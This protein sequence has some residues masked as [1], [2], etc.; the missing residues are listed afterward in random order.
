MN[1]ANE[2]FEGDRVRGG[3]SSSVWCL[4]AAFGTYF[5][6][7]AFR[8]PFTAAGY[9]DLELGGI[10][11]KA[12]LV[13]AQVLGYTVSKFIGIKVVAEIDPRRRAALLLGLIGV[14]EVALVLFGLTPAPYNL[15]WLF[16]NGL[17]LGMVFGLV[18]GFLEGR[19]HTEALAAGLCASFI[20]ADGVTKSAGAALLA[21]GISEYWMPALAGLL[22]V[23]P[24]LMFTWML[25]RIP[26]PTVHD[27]AARSERTPMNGADRWSFF[28]RYAVG[29]VLLVL[30]YLLV[31]VLRSLRADFAP[32]I[33]AGLQANVPAS[34]FAWSE[35]AVAA[36]VLLLTSATVLIRDNRRAFFAGLAT[37][38]AGALL[39]GLALLGHSQGWLSPF[40]FMVTIG[41]GLYLPYIA[42]HVTI[43]ERLIATTRDRGN[44]G[45]LMYVA[46]SFGYLGYV[47]V[48]LARNL[49][50]PAENFLDFFL[51]ASG[52][53]AV[54]CLVLLVPC[55]RFFA[56]HMAAQHSVEFVAEKRELE[57]TA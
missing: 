10:G 24:L 9:Q 35:T 31:T 7:Y 18:L 37:A 43:F 55:W 12:V 33:W 36:G 6:M 5:C 15:V 39:V 38:V 25:T 42:V 16:G 53:V 34:T 50:G 40:A 21:A 13:I 1:S 29:L 17:P 28:H 48:L 32:E 47:G 56:T 44:I 11:Y 3:L 23:P 20:A 26:P 41:I 2:H 4:V 52:I 30:V 22:F 49:L 14:A 57:P 45:Y 19:R 8:K 54:A 27:V 46:D 51:T